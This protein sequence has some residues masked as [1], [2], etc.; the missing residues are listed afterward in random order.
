MVYKHD[1][2]KTTMKKKINNITLTLNTPQL[3]WTRVCGQDLEAKGYNFK[4][5]GQKVKMTPC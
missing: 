5:E 2:L 1:L 4:V 3:G